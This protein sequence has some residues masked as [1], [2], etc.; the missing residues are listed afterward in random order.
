M[1]YQENFKRYETK[2]RMTKVQQE[3][4]LERMQEYMTADEYSAST[5]RNIYF[6]TNTYQLIR[7]SMEKP[8]YK[9]KLRIRSYRTVKETED[10][11]VEIK[12]K[13]DKVV[14]KRRLTMPE[15][16]AMLWVMGR[17]DTYPQTQIGKE[18][19]Y[20]CHYYP[21][22]KPAVFL[23]YDRTAYAGIQDKSFRITFDSNILARTKDTRLIYE[24]SGTPLLGEEEV[25][26]EVKSNGGFPLWLVHFL[27]EEHIYHT[28]FSKYGEAYKTIIFPETPKV[29]Q[30]IQQGRTE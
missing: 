3:K 28:S 30:I 9:E 1:A 24:P 26:M 19:D 5:I 16:E 8:K 27:T 14:Y 6:D 22:L 10:V 25:L 29:Y 21:S 4:M 2:Y 12:K 18:I 20:F 17:T 11:F 13:Y 15:R 23:S 7:T